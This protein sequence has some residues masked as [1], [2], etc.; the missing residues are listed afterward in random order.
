MVLNLLRNRHLDIRYLYI[1]VSLAE[2]SETERE[3]E[4]EGYY[5]KCELKTETKT[6]K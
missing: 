5:K 4:R 6:D 3:A 1:C 2:R